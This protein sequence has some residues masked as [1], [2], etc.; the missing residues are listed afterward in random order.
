MRLFLLG[1]GILPNLLFPIA[2]VFFQI[3]FLFRKNSPL[4][5]N[6]IFLVFLFIL[7]LAAYVIPKKFIVSLFLGKAGFLSL[8]VGVLLSFDT[9]P[10]FENDHFRYFWEG[11]VLRSGFN[12]YSLS[13]LQLQGTLSFP[14]FNQIGY[15]ELTSVYPPIILILFAIMGVFSFKSGL[16]ILGLI[17]AFFLNQIFEDLKER[18]LS[19]FFLFVSFF[20]LFREMIVQHHFEIIAF[21]PFW[22]GIRASE[23]G[24]KFKSFLGFFLSFQL[25][26]LGVIGILKLRKRG[27]WILFCLSIGLSLYVFHRVG[28]PESRGLQAFKE[29]WLFAPAAMN[30]IMAT[31]LSFKISKII[32]MVGFFLT[33]IIAWVY[34]R[35]NFFLITLTAFF[36]FS[37]VYNSWYA[38]WVG[39]ILLYYGF[40]EG[41]WILYFSPLTYLFFTHLKP[42]LFLGNLILHIP[43]Y[44]SLYRLFSFK[45]QSYSR[46]EVLTS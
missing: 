22:I 11:L 21:F 4:Y 40:K 26:F 39:I 23:E 9:H 33:V 18:K 20:Y 37:P 16:I 3:F 25:K 36:I 45:D 35:K 2:G 14:Y 29:K 34:K 46:N 15:P 43:L 12:P 27:E 30:L 28:L 38:L 17:S 19:P 13:P 44:F 32:S 24:D 10:F 7:P 1:R 42:F 6:E 31:G 41:G 8:V 5:L